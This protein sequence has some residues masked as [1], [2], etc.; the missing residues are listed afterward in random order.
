[1]KK[2]SLQLLV[3]LFLASFFILSCSSSSDD[4]PEETILS[5]CLKIGDSHQ[6]G[7]IFYIDHTNEHGLIAAMEDQNS[8]AIWGC[9]ESTDPIANQRDIGFGNAN[10][11]AIVNNCTE[12]NTAAK[13]CSEL[14]LN[15]YDDWFLPTIHELELLY[16]NRDL[17]GGFT[18]TNYSSATESK[19]TDGNYKYVFTID[20]VPNPV[21]ADR[22]VEILKTVPLP[23]RAIRKF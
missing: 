6:G 9:P 14:S 5:D 7:I 22:Q 17:V 18:N 10:T 23:V 12:E 4:A 21:Y 8:G 2:H 13:I 19:N 20:F 16:Y 1:M 15:G 3:Q 11:S